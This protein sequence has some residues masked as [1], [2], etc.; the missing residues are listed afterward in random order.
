LIHGKNNESLKPH[1]KISLV[2]RVTHSQIRVPIRYKE[3]RPPSPFEKTTRD[4]KLALFRHC[5][6]DVE[7]I[8]AGV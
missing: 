8:V 6:S 2:E 4:P 7:I 3:R 1:V 5:G